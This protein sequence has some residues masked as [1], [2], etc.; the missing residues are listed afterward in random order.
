M[1]HAGYKNYQ[2]EYTADFWQHALDISLI[3]LEYL[4]SSISDYKRAS[5]DVVINIETLKILG[6]FNES[7]WK[8]RGDEYI[9][10]M[11]NNH[12]RSGIS[13]SNSRDGIRA[14]EHKSD[15]S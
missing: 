14:I 7:Y 6:I 9:T 5:M 15:G 12:A 2:N 4:Y 1:I 3:N 10:A 8:C 13:F 11:D